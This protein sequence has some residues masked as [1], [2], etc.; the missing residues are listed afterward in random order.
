VA[1]SIAKKFR[2]TSWAL[3]IRRAKKAMTKR[4]NFFMILG[5]NGLDC[6]KLGTKL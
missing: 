4:V 1:S 3:T 5:L 6:V 2:G